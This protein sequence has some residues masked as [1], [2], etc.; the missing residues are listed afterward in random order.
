MLYTSQEFLL[1]FIYMD[2]LFIFQPIHVSM[3]SYDVFF[4]EDT[5][6]GLELFL[7]VKNKSGTSMHTGYPETTKLATSG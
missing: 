7:W 3:K 5:P 1:K 4:K 6:V 2:F